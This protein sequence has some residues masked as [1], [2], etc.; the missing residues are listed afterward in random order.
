MKQKSRRKPGHHGS[1]KNTARRGVTRGAAIGQSTKN[2]V[3]ETIEKTNNR[4]S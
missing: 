4:A 3:V 1:A 2:E